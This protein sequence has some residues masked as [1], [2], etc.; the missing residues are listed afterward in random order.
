MAVDIKQVSRTILEEVLKKGNIEYLD[1]VCDPS[2]KGHDPLMG[3]MDLAAV[4][5]MFE[6]YRTS[7]PDIEPTL[8]GICAEGDTVCTYWRCTGTHQKPFLGAAP[9]GKTLAIDGM[10]FDRFRNGKL[11]ESASQYDTLGLLMGVGL[12]PKIPLRP[13]TAEPERRPHA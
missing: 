12:I 7:F 1:Q 11:V 4:K 5:R 10:S 3:D 13:P 9:T 6:A 2:F 8:L